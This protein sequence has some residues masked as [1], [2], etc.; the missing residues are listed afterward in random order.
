MT[1][2]ILIP[3][4]YSSPSLARKIAKNY[5][6]SVKTIQVTMKGADEVSSLLARVEQ[7]KSRIHQNPFALD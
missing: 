1:E 3:V 7:A 6:K 4:R 5:G 2:A